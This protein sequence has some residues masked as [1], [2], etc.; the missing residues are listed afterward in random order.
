MLEA[1][2]FALKINKSESIDEYRIGSELDYAKAKRVET[3]L[4][5]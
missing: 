3:F 4:K 5:Q 1:G 2:Y